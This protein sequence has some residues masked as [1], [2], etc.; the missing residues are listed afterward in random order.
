MMINGAKRVLTFN[1]LSKLQQDL[2]THINGD[3]Y[4]EPWEIVETTNEYMIFYIRMPAKGGK[5]RGCYKIVFCIE[6]KLSLE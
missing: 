5:T 2:V 3:N 6:G 1:K 4:Q